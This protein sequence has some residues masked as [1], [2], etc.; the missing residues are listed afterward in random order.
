MFAQMSKIYRHIEQRVGRIVR[1]NSS[2]R[3]VHIIW[4]HDAP[5]FTVTT[6][7]RAFR[8]AEDI[9]VIFGAN[10]DTPEELHK[11]P[12]TIDDEYAR[13]VFSEQWGKLGDGQIITDAFEPIR[14]LAY[15]PTA[16]IPPGV[17]DAFRTTDVTVVG[18]LKLRKVGIDLSQEYESALQMFQMRTG[19]E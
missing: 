16:M 17:Y 15:G 3:E 7:Q 8:T 4:P 9:K 10:L 18:R 6:D 13:N 19:G 14:S 11:E 1:M 12:V 2:F 5:E